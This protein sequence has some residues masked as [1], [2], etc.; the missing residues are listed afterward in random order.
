MDADKLQLCAALIKFTFH[1]ITGIYL[2]QE[3]YV[4]PQH[5]A[6]F[7]CVKYKNAH[8]DSFQ[9]MAHGVDI[10]NAVRRIV[11]PLTDIKSGL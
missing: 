6:V 4:S 2:L 8:G 7:R 9:Y 11:R 1:V 3:G 5:I 10:Y